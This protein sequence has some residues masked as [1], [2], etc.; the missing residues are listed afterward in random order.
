[1]ANG[2]PKERW[3]HTLLRYRLTKQTKLGLNEHMVSKTAAFLIPWG[4]ACGEEGAVS[5]HCQRCG[6][7]ISNGM[8]PFRPTSRGV[9]SVCECNDV[10]R[11]Q[12]IAQVCTRAPGQGSTP[13]RTHS[14]GFVHQHSAGRRQDKDED[15]WGGGWNS[16]QHV[17]L[18]TTAAAARELASRS[19]LAPNAAWHAA[20]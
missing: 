8:R 1:M 15:V 20:W 2:R 13:A 6:A 12:P 7:R 11:G 17:N 18:P 9:H 3:W 4:G 14:R 16:A 5:V 19:V 10:R